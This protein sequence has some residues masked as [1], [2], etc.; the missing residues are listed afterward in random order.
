MTDRTDRADLTDRADRAD[1]TDWADMTDMV[2]RTPS[3]ITLSPRPIC[4]LYEDDKRTEDL[5]ETLIETGFPE[6]K[7][8]KWVIVGGHIDI[9]TSSPPQKQW[10]YFSRLSASAAMRKHNGSIA[11][12][13]HIL[14]WLD[15]HGCDVVNGIHALELEVSKVKQ[16]MSLMTVGVAFPSTRVISNESTVGPAVLSWLA[17]KKRGVFYI[18][19]VTGGS[20]MAVQRFESPH[21]FQKELPGLFK[22]DQRA[23]DSMYILQEGKEQLINWFHRTKKKLVGQKKLFY[24]MEF[25]DQEFLYVL[26]IATPVAVHTSCPACDAPTRFDN[27]FDIIPNPVS[28]F[29]K[30]GQWASFV[31]KCKLFM[32]QNAMFIGAFE[33]SIVDNTF[34]VYDVNTNTNYNKK[35][36]KALP[37]EKR[38]LVQTAAMLTKYSLENKDA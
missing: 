37:R 10:L 14:Q 35:A 36:E 17:K 28:Y 34:F 18:K 38:G 30:T 4:I 8:K 23:P 19:P 20:G 32:K 24:R 33:F 7:I 3:S 22:K 1:M 26:R 6:N 5:I 21:Q 16:Y 9:D 13:R 27:E 15:V 29:E 12:G 11:F 25:I 2:D 31:K